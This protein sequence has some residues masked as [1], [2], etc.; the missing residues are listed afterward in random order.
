MGHTVLRL[1]GRILIAVVCGLVFREGTCV[2]FERVRIG[3][4]TVSPLP[5]AFG[6]RA[7]DGTA[8]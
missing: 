4:R 3:L 6:V 1:A 2:E 7:D 8:P 5:E